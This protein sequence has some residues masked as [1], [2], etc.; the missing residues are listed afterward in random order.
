MV[1]VDARLAERFWPGRDAVGRYLIEPL[2]AEALSKPGPDNMRRRRVVG[3][4]REVKQHAL[5]TPA[6][7]VGSYYFPLGQSV[8]GGVTLAV[9]GDA[10]ATAVAADLGGCSPSS[11]PGCRCSTSR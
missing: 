2:S 1:I 7:A 4:V 6:D 10:L 11:I 8:P 5:V 9:Q 3:V